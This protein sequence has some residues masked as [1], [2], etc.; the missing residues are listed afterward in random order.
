[1]HVFEYKSEMSNILITIIRRLF[2]KNKVLNTKLFNFKDKFQKIINTLI[3][4]RTSC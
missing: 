4:I 2:E 3:H 1:M